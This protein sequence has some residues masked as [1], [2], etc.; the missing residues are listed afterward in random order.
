MATEYGKWRPVK[1][2]SEGGQAHTFIVEDNSRQE[3]G[4]YVLK[5]LKNI[6]RIYRFE[7]EI[8]AVSRL[9]HPNIVRLMDYNLG[10]NRPYIVF[11]FC[12]GG[13]LADADIRSLTLLQKLTI[14]RTIVL[15]ISYAH[16][17]KI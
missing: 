3:R 1:A 4:Q 11:E 12:A 17:K 16:S 5:R 10:G 14:F 8:Q 2:L 15:A 13:T 6:K 7:R 9:S